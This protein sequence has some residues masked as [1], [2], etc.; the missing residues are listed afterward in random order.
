MD[1]LRPLIDLTTKENPD[2]RPTAGELEV[3][4]ME[5]RQNVITPMGIEEEALIPYRPR[6]DRVPVRT[7]PPRPRQRSEE[8]ETTGFF[9]YAVYLGK[10]LFRWLGDI[11]G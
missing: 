6:V 2:A 7:A 10:N 1:F 9:G 3:W 4:W 5:Y 11:S 8:G